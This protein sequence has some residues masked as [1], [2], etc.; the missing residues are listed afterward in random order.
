MPQGGKGGK[1]LWEE[2]GNLSRGEQAL[3][4]NGGTG[5]QTGK[6]DKD[7]GKRRVEILGGK[8]LRGET[9]ERIL[10]GK[11]GKRS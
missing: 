1:D 7:F 5:S 2:K 11:R 6:G 8:G 9:G 3:R 10:S 4:G